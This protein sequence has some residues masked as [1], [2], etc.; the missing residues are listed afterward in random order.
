MINLSIGFTKFV[1]FG[2]NYF[3]Y[4]TYQGILYKI[5]TRFIHLKTNIS[6]LFDNIFRRFC[7]ISP[8]DQKAVRP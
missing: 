8:I 3:N 1:E 4:L 5:C 7:A 6:P 2:G